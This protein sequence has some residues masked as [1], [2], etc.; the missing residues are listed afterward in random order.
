MQAFTDDKEATAMTCTLKNSD[1][2]F[3]CPSSD[4]SS[5]AKY[6]ATAIASGGTQ[7]FES[8]SKLR[9]ME[10]RS[11]VTVSCQGAAAHDVHAYPDLAGAIA[12]DLFGAPIRSHI[13]AS[14]HKE[15]NIIAGCLN[16]PVFRAHLRRKVCDAVAS[17][18][19]TL[20]I[21]D[22]LAS[23]AS[24]RTH[25]GCFCD[26]CVSGFTEFL[27]KHS[28]PMLLA[29]LG[30]TT[31][32][33]FDF[34]AF[35]KKAIGS[36]TDFISLLTHLPLYNEYV[37]YQL[38]CANENVQS[39][40]RLATDISRKGVCVSAHVLLSD[41]CQTAIV[42]HL[43]YF[44]SEI[45]HQNPIQS[46]SYTDVV[47]LYRMAECLGR[48]LAATASAS[49][50]LYIRDNH[51][52]ELASIWIALSYAS[53]A[54]FM[55]PNKVLC[56]VEDNRPHWYCGPSSTFAPLYAFVKKH[57]DL[58][59]G[60]SAAGP[61]AIPKGIAT[62]F[63]MHQNRSALQHALSAGNAEPLQAQEHALVLPR[64]KSDGSVAIHIVNTEY[65]A[66]RRRITPQTAVQIR[67]PAGIFS[68]E[69]SHATVHCYGGESVRVD[70]TM[71]GNALCFTL[72]QL[73]VWDIATF[74][75]WA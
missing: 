7:S 66:A 21:D 32:D 5:Y 10:I 44:T 33:G 74:E 41:I 38:T 51:A 1:I 8:I 47:A 56:C 64:I 26:F 55:V 53:G 58:L 35:A 48:P 17:A 46:S 34:R 67:L 45:P 73:A 49:D 61:L 59:N 65:Y 9:A 13:A 62:T 63:D 3:V 24:I 71:D 37:D 12:K 23:A 70:V 43:S 50:W 18:P 22:H 60:F 72:P 52:D 14:S 31:F 54:C 27:K 16:H 11:A 75:Y 4:P 39:L 29:T 69:Y 2:V 30:I 19:D 6:G 57:E 15:S 25:G 40:C 28:D 20:H 42:P 36:S 68:R